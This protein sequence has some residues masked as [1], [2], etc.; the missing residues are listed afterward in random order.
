MAVQI[1]VRHRERVVLALIAA[2][3]L[4][5][6]V[7]VARHLRQAA[8]NAS[9][10]YGRLADGLDLIDDLQFN[11][12]ET[13]RTLLYA[14]HTSDANRQLAYAEQSRAAETIVD[15]RLS[16]RSALT[17]APAAAGQMARLRQAWRRYLA[18]RDEV[19]GLILEGSFQEGVALDEQLG[20]L[21]FNE[22]RDAIAILKQ[23]FESDA[24]AR[25]AALQRHADSATRQLSVLV[26]SGL[27]AA[28]V[29]VYLVNRRAAAE[30]LLRVEAH[31]GSIL[32]AVPNPII[33][34]DAD[35]RII[36]LNEAAERTFGVRRSDV[37]GAS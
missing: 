9:V 5:M 18:V 15:Q 6:G 17:S 4:G 14:L 26:V 37:L 2:V 29:G 3:V 12:Q 35:G 32:Q 25:A 28:L 21:R 22:V 1:Q 19:I 11:I 23:S 20:A 27:A 10:L 36:E 8:E 31:N 24:A 30:R 16:D 34:T 7:V 13:R 33:S